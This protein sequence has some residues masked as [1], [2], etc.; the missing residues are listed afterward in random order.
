MADR[1]AP[2]DQGLKY[3]KLDEQEVKGIIARELDQA[4]GVEGG[5]LSQ[6]RQNALQYYQ[7]NPFGNEV[8]GRSQVVM[9]S[10]LETVEWVL[11]A[12]LRIFTASDKIAEIEPT[13][14][15]QEAAGDEATDYIT[16]IF[17]KDNDGFLILHDWFKDALTQKLGW[18]KRWWDTGKVPEFNSYTGLN[19]EQYAALKTPEA[20]VV[21]EKSY[22]APPDSLMAGVSPG[23]LLYDCTLRTMREEG[24]VKIENVP[25]EEVLVS[26]HAKRGAIPFLCH[27]RKRTRSDLLADGYDDDTLDVLSTY[28]SA[29]YNAERLARYESEDDF[30]TENERTDTPMRE[31]WVEESYVRYDLDGDGIAELCKIVTSGNGAVILTKDKKPDI[32]P[33]DEVPLVSICPIPMP[34]KLV[35]MSLADLVMDLQL[36]LSTL[37]RQML[38]NIYLT[39]NPRMEVPDAAVNDNTIDDL[40]TSRPG[41]IIRTKAG[42]ELVPIT[43]PFVAEKA[44][45][46]VEY[47]N[48]SARS[49]PA[50]RAAIRAS[51]PTI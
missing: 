16:Q 43:T 51:R 30:P 50:S 38:D 13:R 41:G 26:R 35:G 22:P 18:V 47:F 9:R 31:F 28:D 17:Y 44:M 46:L 45:T 29:E 21:E 3:K 14:P 33:I 15:D 24:R 48:E 12:L 20:T 4:L 36:I 32:E 1:A 6:D 49:A 19:A 2:P 39:N 5:R 34:H 27:R 10:V 11:P 7:G 42:G 25:P 40:L 23:A 8:D 37:V